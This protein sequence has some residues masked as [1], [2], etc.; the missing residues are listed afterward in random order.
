VFL[1]AG[2]KAQAIAIHAVSKI[3]HFKKLGSLYWIF[4]TSRSHLQDKILFVVV[5][6]I[7]FSNAIVILF[8]FFFV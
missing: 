1:P 2:T 5:V 3:E 6:F 4:A 7:L 8:F